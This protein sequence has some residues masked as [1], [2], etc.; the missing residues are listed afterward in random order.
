MQDRLFE[1]LNGG[2]AYS[3]WLDTYFCPRF[4]RE[5][6]RRKADRSAYWGMMWSRDRDD[7]V[8]GYVVVKL[9]ETDVGHRLSLRAP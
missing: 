8:K 2:K 9:G 7:G 1:N 6:P 5:D 4:L 3:P